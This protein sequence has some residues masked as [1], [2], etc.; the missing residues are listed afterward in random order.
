M[1][2]S[3]HQ[4]G[5]PAQPRPSSPGRRGLFVLLCVAGLLYAAG[6][7]SHWRFQRDSARYMALARS[8]AEGDGYRLNYK[9]QTRVWPGFPAMLVPVYMAV[10]ESFLAMNILLSLLGL[11]SVAAAWALFRQLPLNSRQVTACTLLFGFSRTLYYYSA[12]IM[13]DVPFTFFALVTLICGTMMLR[14][15]GRAGWLWCIAASV[16]ACVACF[17]RPVGPALVIALAL[18]VWVTPGVPKGRLAL[19]RTLVILGPILAAGL[20]W[21]IR[22]ALLRTRYDFSYFQIFVGRFGVWGLAGRMV[23]R[24]PR[25]VQSLADTVLGTDLGMAAGVLLGALM[26]LGLFAALRR[27]ERLVSIYGLVYLIGICVASPNRRYLLPALPA[28][29]YWLV[30]GCQL[31]GALLQTRTHALTARRTAVLGSV[32]LAMAVSTNVGRIGKL[33][34]EARAP[35]FYARLDDG[36]LLDY[37]ALADWLEANAAADDVVLAR[38]YETVHYFSRVR[39]HYVPPA[40]RWWGSKRAMGFIRGAGVSL[41]IWDPSKDDLTARLPGIARAHP[42]V[43]VPVTRIG[44]LE[45]MRIRAEGIPPGPGWSDAQRAGRLSGT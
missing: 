6:I 38:E 44:R 11:G 20:A 19:G 33:V 35:G 25:I 5:P 24:A 21:G 43:F 9:V 41:V 22:C 40:M 18:S 15:S 27:G 28:L 34:Y 36:R 23:S 3:D 4:T 42:E 45:I 12:H 30:L 16:A 13:S 39:T 7:N 14:R 1:P 29:V 32:L 31:A 17:V 26:A 37:F 8:V 10:G 2:E